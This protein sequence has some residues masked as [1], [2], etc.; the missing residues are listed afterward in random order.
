MS[1]SMQYQINLHSFFSHWGKFGQN[2]SKA[3]LSYISDSVEYINMMKDNSIEKQ[4]WLF[5]NDDFGALRWQAKE[6][7][8]EAL[9][10]TNVVLAAYT[11][12]QA[13]LKLYT[14][15]EGLGDQVVYMDTDRYY[16]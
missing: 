16:Y 14:L 1:I 9:P 7:F 6:E 13:R 5:V 4:D 15:L 3:K 12:A 10:N 2:P 8:V 11:T